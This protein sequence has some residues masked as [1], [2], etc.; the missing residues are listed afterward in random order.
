MR[1]LK[2]LLLIGLA[3][4][5]VYLLYMCIKYDG[6]TPVASIMN[7]SPSEVITYPDDVPLD[8]DEPVLFAPADD[9]I[10][11]TTISGGL[12]IKIPHPTPLTLRSF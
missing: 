1:K 11:P 6:T 7:V 10:I 8:D 2:P 9:S 4:A 12:T 3:A 5:A